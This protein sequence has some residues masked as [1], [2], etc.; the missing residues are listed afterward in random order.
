MKIVPPREEIDPEETL[1]SSAEEASTTEER[2]FWIIHRRVQ[3]R[4]LITWRDTR[5]LVLSAEVPLV[6]AG[7]AY[8]TL[9]AIIPI[10]V[11]SFAVFETVGGFDKL[12][13]IIRPFIVQNLA[14]GAGET[15]LREIERVVAQVNPAALGVTGL[16]ALILT[17]MALFSTVESAVNRVW[18]TTISRSLFQRIS[19]YWLFLSLGPLVLAIVLG[20]TTSQTLSLG[21]AFPDGTQGFLIVVL[22]CFVLYKWVPDRKV[23]RLAAIIG[24]LFTAVFFQLARVGVAFYTSQ[25]GLYTNVYGGLAFIAIM[26]LWVY[27]AWVIFLVGAALSCAIQGRIDQRAEEDLDEA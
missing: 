5:R 14:E 24:A 9:G 4:F 1:D 6:A 17:S 16:A 2:T 27:I 20:L 18:K 3:D 23:H 26:L 8:I 22:V 11:V 13:D 7:L 12:M 15:A 25:V 21:A 10:L 19:A